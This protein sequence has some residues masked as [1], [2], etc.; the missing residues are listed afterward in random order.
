MQM[1]E[2]YRGFPASAMTFR[3]AKTKKAFVE[4]QRDDKDIKGELGLYWLLPQQSN[5]L[6]FCMD[7]EGRA[8]HQCGEVVN[9]SYSYEQVIDIYMEIYEYMCIYQNDR[10]FS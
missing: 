6:R 9:P 2:P 3:S 4:C 1:E 10:I 8:R 7:Y 5:K